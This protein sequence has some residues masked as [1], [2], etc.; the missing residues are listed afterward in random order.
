MPFPVNPELLK[1]LAQ[2]T[3][4]EM[5]VATD[6]N[7]L[8]G[9]LSRRARQAREDASFE[10]SV[11][12]L[13]GPVRLPALARR[14]AARARRAAARARAAE[15][16]VK[17]AQPFWLFGTGLA[18]RRG[19]ALDRRRRVLRARRAAASATSRIVR[20]LVTARAGGRRALKGVLLVLA[21]ALGV[22]RAGAA[23]VRPRHAPHPGDQPRC[24]D[25][26]RLL[27]EHVRARRARR[28]ASRAPR[29]RSRG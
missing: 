16:S 21:V 11:A 25:R 2:K 18:L 24:G 29:A 27:E 14:A 1:E 23:A 3:G 22:R 20:A 17:F 9:E 5:Y 8:A 7:A 4:G 6:A 28:R 10:A 13:R 12:T 19:G 26:A 15:V